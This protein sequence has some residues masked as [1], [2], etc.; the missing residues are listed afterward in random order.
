[1]RLEIKIAI[2]KTGQ[3]QYQIAQ[4]LGVSE[5]ALS[6]FIRGRGKLQPEQEARLTA[7][8]KLRDSSADAVAA[9]T[10]GDQ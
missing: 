8:L 9:G 7:L 4:A 1:M 5:Y 3:P 6:K 10:Q 2:I